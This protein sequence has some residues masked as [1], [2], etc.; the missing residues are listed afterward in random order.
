MGS[1]VVSG[2]GGGG[3]CAKTAK[4]LPVAETITTSATSSLRG[5]EKAK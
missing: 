5:G 2:G 3:G 4:E 1:A